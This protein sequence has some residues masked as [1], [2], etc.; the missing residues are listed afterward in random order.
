MEGPRYRIG[1]CTGG[2]TSSIGP[3]R[4]SS[5]SGASLMSENGSIAPQVNPDRNLRT[6]AGPAPHFDLLSQT[7]DPLA[8]RRET[9]AGPHREGIEPSAVVHNLCQ[10]LLVLHS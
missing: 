7:F 5:P 6:L 8:H 2:C 1:R 3:R 9:H 4:S 10:H